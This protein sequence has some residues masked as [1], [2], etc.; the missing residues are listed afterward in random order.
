MK[1]TVIVLLALIFTAPVM[2]A[3]TSI[4]IN[5]LGDGWIAIDYN[6]VYGPNI[7]AFALKVSV[8][9]SATIFDVCDY[10]VGE[11]TN[12]T[13]GGYGIFPST[14][15]IVDG[16]VT[17]YNVPIAPNTATGATGTGLDTN[18]VIL[19]LGALY[20]DGN[21]PPK[22]GRL[23]VI[24]VDG[25]G[26]SD[27]NVCV[28]VDT[29]RGSIVREDANEET[30]TNLPVCENVA[31][32][33]TIDPIYGVDRTYADITD[34]TMMGPPDG[35]IDWRDL[36][37]PIIFWNVYVANC[38]ATAYPSLCPNADITDSTMTGPPDGYI[39]WRDLQPILIFW[40]Q[41][42]CQ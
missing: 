42:V 21:A 34:S 9:N 11:S 29:I 33:S 24:G 30:F 39:D 15:V 38:G 35:I 37:Y 26:A 8:D 27:A 20:E 28:D 4:D 12:P 13:T 36:Q 22:T 3:N 23:C 1:K 16:N 41:A 14:I 18:S 32:C 7:S 2:A 40:N 10:Y 5:D 25:G 19:E 17:D 6:T 31:L